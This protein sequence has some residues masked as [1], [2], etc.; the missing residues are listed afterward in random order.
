MSKKI[1]ANHPS[2]KHTPP[3]GSSAGGAASDTE[4]RRNNIADVLLSA[5][6]ALLIFYPPYF[7]GLFF[8][9]AMLN[10]LIYTGLLF[11][12]YAV[13]KLLRGEKIFSRSLLDWIVL[14]YAV[15][16]LVALIGAL[17]F[18]QALYSFYKLFSLAL[19]FWLITDTARTM[20]AVR[21]IMMILVS[22]SLF[23][24]VIGIG[25]ATGIKLLTYN[26]AFVNGVVMSTLQ[27]ANATSVYMAVLSM[28]AITLSITERNAWQRFLFSWIASILMFISV[29]SASKGAWVVFGFGLILFLIGMPGLYKLRSIFFFGSSIGAALLTADRFMPYVTTLGR[30]NMALLSLLI[31]VGVMLLAH[32]LWEG[33][34]LV[35]ARKGKKIAL[36]MVAVLLAAAVLL[37]VV[38]FHDNF[39]NLIPANVRGELVKLSDFSNASYAT[40][41]AMYTDALRITADNPLNGVGGKGW[42]LSYHAYQDYQYWSTEVHSFFLQTG[43]EAGISGL[44]LLLAIYGVLCLYIFRLYKKQRDTQADPRAFVTIWGIFSAAMAFSLHALFDFD[45]SIPALQMILF[46]FM[47]MIGGIYYAEFGGIRFKFSKEVTLTLSVAGLLIALHAALWLSAFNANQMTLALIRSNGS[48]DTALNYAEKSIQLDSSNAEYRVNLAGLYE[49]YARQLPNDNPSKQQLYMAARN[50]VELAY[51]ASPSNLRYITTL[52]SIAQN[53]GDFP[54]ALKL[55]ERSVALNP[56]FTDAYNNLIINHTQAAIYWASKNDKP[57]AVQEIESALSVPD[58]IRSQAERINKDHLRFWEGSPL[59]VGPST[60][61]ALVGPMYLHG[62]YQKVIA[63]FKSLE[64]DHLA[65]NGDLPAFYAASLYRLGQTSQASAVAAA[66]QTSNPQAFARYQWLIKL[67]PLRS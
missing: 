1:N 20:E 57:R 3:A 42:E 6:L 16:Y 38:S 24:A 21:K 54:T 56:W 18:R 51:K 26:G 9:K 12:A 28:I 17:D 36:G 27:Y 65:P 62:D 4:S 39:A 53:A 5:A 52:V 61:A 19:V 67:P 13:R 40:R 48:P 49:S 45:M 29:C 34:T 15:S 59:A 11:F 33:L 55:N 8:P 64:A 44:L 22:S 25:S 35:A 23:V 47:A 30:P 41:I 10:T 46:I 7:Q 58:R 14:L 31:S 37:P 2:I 60:Q 32:F 63:L 50:Q 66:L 43:V